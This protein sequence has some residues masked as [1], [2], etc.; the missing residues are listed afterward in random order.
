ME[1]ELGRGLG[2]SRRGARLRA[3]HRACPVRA[4]PP[5]EG[6][7]GGNH[8]RHRP[9]LRLAR[10]PLHDVHA[11]L[12]LQRRAGR[13]AGRLLPAGALLAAG[14]RSALGPGGPDQV[15]APDPGPAVRRGPRRAAAAPADPLHPGLPHH[16][17]GRDDP[18]AP[19]WR[20]PR[21]LRPHAG[22]PGLARLA[23]QPLGAGAV[24]AL[25]PDPE[26]GVRARA[27][28]PLLLR[29][30]APLHAAGCGSRRGSADRGS[31]HRE[32]L[33]LPVRDLVRPA[34]PGR[35][36]R[37]AQGGPEQ[38]FPTPEPRTIRA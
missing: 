17:G 26:Q 6:R 2:C 20:L 11:R 38:R 1:R 7:P 5:G 10:L 22:L 27:R 28:G 12:E 23:V 29:A 21:A 14:P 3:A 37:T 4:G 19:R 8:P 18:A 15:R 31:G 33:V 16:R 36:V 35:P 13:P 32:P 24:A 9:G 34:R 30:R 25:P